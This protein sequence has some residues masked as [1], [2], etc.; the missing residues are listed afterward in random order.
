M[1]DMSDIGMLRFILKTLY[2]G[3]RDLLAAKLLDRFGSL[4]GIFKASYEELCAVE[5]ITERVATFFVFAEPVF[6][7]AIIRAVDG[8]PLASEFATAQYALAFTMKRSRK[9][10][11][12]I[13]LTPKSTVLRTARITDPD[14]VRE[15]VCR[16]CRCNAAKAIWLCYKPFAPILEPS[17]TRLDAI[18]T[19]S[20]TL[21]ALGIELVDY[22]EYA[23][24]RMFGLRRFMSGDVRPVDIMSTSDAPYTRVDIAEGARAFGKH[25]RLGDCV[26]YPMP[27]KT[28]S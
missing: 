28:R 20:D 18:A 8:L 14:T 15:I 21:A 4:Q 26:V 17:T 16:A 12:C 22:I 19:V 27:Y 7:Q 3:E 23:P 11:Y 9:A 24:Y 6:R 1:A 2:Y 10:D 13:Y 5:G 25:R